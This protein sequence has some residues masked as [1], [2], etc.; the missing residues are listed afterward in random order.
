M[1]K[2]STDISMFWYRYNG[3]CWIDIPTLIHDWKAIQTTA[4]PSLIH[5]R[6]NEWSSKQQQQQQKKDQTRSIMRFYNFQ[7][8]LYIF[9]SSFSFFVFPPHSVPNRNCRILFLYSSLHHYNLNSPPTPLPQTKFKINSLL[10]VASKPGTLLPAHCWH[11]I[12]WTAPKPNHLE[13]YRPDFF[14][15]EKAGLKSKLYS[16]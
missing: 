9:D 14:K 1:K 6:N 13:L 7:T 11:T 16:Q 2:I 8:M 5:A 4:T 3:S 15:P 10:L 12:H